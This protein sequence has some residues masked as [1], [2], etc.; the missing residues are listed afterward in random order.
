MDL[1][2]VLKDFAAAFGLPALALDQGQACRL[3]LADGT[4]MVAEVHAEGMLLHS[5]LGRV[6][7]DEGGAPIWDWLLR[8]N[9]R[10]AGGAFGL[11]GNQGEIL[12]W[13]HFDGASTTPETFLA[14]LAAFV[15]ALADARAR[16][17]EYSTQGGHLAAHA[18]ADRP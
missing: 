9:D 4:E 15:D 3:V 6:P 2:D 10:A 7:V 8:A 16:F 14:G 11:D 13:R 18:L 17:L 12:F 5:V 1:A